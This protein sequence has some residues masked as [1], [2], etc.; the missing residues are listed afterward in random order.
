MIKEE[1]SVDESKSSQSRGISKSEE[2]LNEF[3]IDD[4]NISKESSEFI[5]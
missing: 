4:E 2:G 3:D 1:L 5:P